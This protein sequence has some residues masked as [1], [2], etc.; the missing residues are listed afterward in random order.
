MACAA[1]TAAQ[2]TYNVTYPIRKG[3]IDDWDLMEKFWEQSIFKYMRCEPEDHYFFLV[4]RRFL[5]RPSAGAGRGW[6]RA[7]HESGP[8][9]AGRAP[10]GSGQLDGAAPE[11][12]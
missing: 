9:S 7:N 12:A 2:N 8:H 3:Q 10:S 1:G 5:A 6:E 11:R 4:R